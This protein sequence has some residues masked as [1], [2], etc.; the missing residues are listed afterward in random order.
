[1]IL[2]TVKPVERFQKPKQG[3]NYPVGV[4]FK[5]I[6][7]KNPMPSILELVETLKSDS[8]NK[9]K[10]RVASFLKE[11]QSGSL[12]EM[13]QRTFASANYE[14]G[15]F[16][17]FFQEMVSKKTENDLKN[18]VRSCQLTE[19]TM[20]Q[21][22]QQVED[23]IEDE[24]TI[25]HSQLS[26]RIEK[27]YESD[28]TMRELE[29]IF[30]VDPR[31]FSDLAYSPIIQSGGNYDMKVTA[32]PDDKILTCDTITLRIGSKFRGFFS[33]LARTIFISPDSKQKAVY[34]LLLEIQKRMIAKLRPGAKVSDLV[35][36]MLEYAKSKEPLLD[37]KFQGGQL[38]ASI[39]VEFREL[40]MVLSAK[41]ERKVEA[42]M[43][44]N[45]AISV[46][47]IANSK[48]KIYAVALA[49]IVSVEAK[50]TKVLTRSVGKEFNE[51]SF[52]I[53]EE[54]KEKIEE[55]LQKPNKQIGSSTST[56]DAGATNKRRGRRNEITMI[57]MQNDLKRRN[58]QQEL[59]DRKLE[60]LRERMANNEFGRSHNREIIEKVE[61]LKSYS[62]IGQFPTAPN[63]AKLFLDQSRETLLVPFGNT[64]VPFHVST[65][66]SVSGQTEGKNS[67]IRINFHIPGASSLVSQNLRFPDPR[68]NGI[69]GYIHELSL[70]S[71]NEHQMAQMIKGIK[72]VQKKI[73][74]RLIDKSEG[75]HDTE[76]EPLIPLKGKRPV[77]SGVKM[78]PKL[79]GKST[80]GTLEA[81]TNGFRY[82][83]DRGDRVDFTY[84][85]IKQAFF[86][87]I[88]VE[89]IILVHFR[90]HSPLMIQKK[91]TM[92]IQFFMEAGNLTEDLLGRRGRSD[93]DEE[94]EEMREKEQRKRLDRDFE[95]FVRAAQNTVSFLFHSFDSPPLSLLNRE[96][97]K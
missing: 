7:D 68:A 57:N 30:G 10:P 75:L 65:I 76:Q 3:E 91:R 12:S 87:P 60:E 19:K 6:D 47:N 8:G 51:V 72:E 35:S 85:N 74:Q 42:G 88:S 21:L 64:I 13:V 25:T 45:V 94:E 17:P 26:S 23:S 43:V 89:I 36:E 38:G 22:M 52:T 18:I 55:V 58:H 54:D 44:F 40:F 14:K 11:A 41:N 67:A 84:S 9:S 33:N 24:V 77:L 32:E 81:H 71:R 29:K 34:V 86:Q 80:C 5:A 49:D 39:G 16:V 1:M 70:K 63:S 95:A 31:S 97:V 27:W 28:K 53:D 79:P 96:T 83:S 48:G 59:S 50:E 90:L 92:D 56:R 20:K 15:D 46:S 66:K 4:I 37:G 69:Q 82:I 62:S 78:R 61:N 73:K 93:K 2:L